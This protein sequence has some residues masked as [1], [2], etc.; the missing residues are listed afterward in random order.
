MPCSSSSSC[1]QANHGYAPS[2]ENDTSR[3][4]RCQT[5]EEDLDTLL[6]RN[7]SNAHKG[8]AVSV[9]LHDGSIQVAAHTYEHN[10]CRYADDAVE[11]MAR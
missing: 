1:A 8:I 10:L 4:I 9:A 7:L 2:I 11:G 6:P 3:Y 5:A